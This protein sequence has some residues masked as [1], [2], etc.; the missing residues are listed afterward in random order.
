M[1]L[2]LTP[3]LERQIRKHGEESYPWECCGIFGG[4]R[5]G[6][7]RLLNEIYPIVNAREESAKHNRFLMTPKDVLMAE[8]QFRKNGKE[9]LGFYHSHPDHPA[10]PS[11]FDLDHASWPGYSY[12]IVAVEK[13]ISKML[14]SWVLSENRHSFQQEEVLLMETI[15]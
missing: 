12:A 6:D 2:V 9:L 7:K 15:K 5:E 11:A 13:G 4:L 8:K 10:V 14:T 1:A 3:D